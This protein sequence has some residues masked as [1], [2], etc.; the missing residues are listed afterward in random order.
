MET[1]FAVALLQMAMGPKPEENLEKGL[2]MLREA[3]KGGARVVCLP[4]L[5]RTRYFCQREDTA[6]FDLA[7]PVPGP[8]TDALSARRARRRDRRR[9]PR[10]R[11]PRAA[12]VYH[13]SR[14]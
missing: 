5:F 10:L 4:E 2:A 11:A 6:L 3:A 13:N 14:P 7:E 1:R 12:G 9:G 8:T